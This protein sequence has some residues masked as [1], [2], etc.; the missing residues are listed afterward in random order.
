MPVKHFFLFGLDGKH[1]LAFGLMVY[2]LYTMHND[3]RHN[4][5]RTELRQCIMR[6]AGEVRLQTSHR[7]VWEDVFG[8]QLQFTP[9]G[10]RMPGQPAQ[11]ILQTLEQQYPS[12]D[13]H[14]ITMLELAGVAPSG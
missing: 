6:I 3:L 14:D 5:D 9:P 10:Q 1:K 2:A 12:R 8:W 11:N 7:R 4:P 13:I